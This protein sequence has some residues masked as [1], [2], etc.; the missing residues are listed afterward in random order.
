MWMCRV[1]YLR[2]ECVCVTPNYCKSHIDVIATH[3]GAPQR[4]GAAR[5]RGRGP[6]RSRGRRRGHVAC[7]T[8][9]SRVSGGGYLLS[10]IEPRH[11]T[12][13]M[14]TTHT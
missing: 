5:C 4:A 12:T 8:G 2:D 10:C 11:M 7:G 13:P 14:R 9:R 3:S 1:V 6:R